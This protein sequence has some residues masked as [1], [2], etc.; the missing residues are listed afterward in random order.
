MPRGAAVIAYRG[1]RGIVWRI[2][3]V[4][5]DGRQVMETIGGDRRAAEAA[6]YDRL[7]RVEREG[8]RRPAPTTFADAFKGWFDATSS[9]K[10]WRESTRRQYRIVEPRL[11]DEFGSSRLTAI[12][13]ADVAIYVT[14]RMKKAAP[15][16]VSRELT[17]LHSVFEWAISNELLDRNPADGVPHPRTTRRR[18]HALRP[19]QVQALSRSFVNEA[20]RAIFLTLVLTGVRRNELRGLRWR[21]VDLI[22]NVLRVEDSKTDTGVRAIAITPTLA[23]ELWQHRRATSFSGEDERVFCHPETGGPLDPADFRDALNAAF[24]KAGLD[25]PEGFR[26]FHDLRVTAIT[27]DA[28]A[29]ANPIAIMAKA[30]HANMATTKVYL[31]LAGVVFREEA[32]LLE[33]RLLGLSTPLSTHLAAPEPVLADSAPLEQALLT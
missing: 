25:K 10:Q 5:G 15:S 32:E 16:T 12:R 18:G 33:C 4:D 30:G 27:N 17:V 20:D 6:L 22:E 28:L 24:K 7:T 19:E 21:N 11:V 13:R 8:Y 2:K 29:G 1:K 26:P 23:E 14:A 3:Y 9:R 31:K